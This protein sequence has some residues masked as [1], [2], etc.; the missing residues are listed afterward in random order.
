MASN[1]QNILFTEARV[2]GFNIF[3]Y[4][5]RYEDAR[6]RLARWLKEGRLKHREDVVLGLENAPNAF[7]RLFDGGNFGKLIVKVSEE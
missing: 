5:G 2:G 7:L 1:L 6:R 3:S 4:A